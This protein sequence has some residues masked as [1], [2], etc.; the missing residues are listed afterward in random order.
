MW[1]P[2]Y[3]NKGLICEWDPTVTKSLSNQAFDPIV[4][5]LEFDK[6]MVNLQWELAIHF[7]KYFSGREVLSKIVEHAALDIKYMFG[8]DVD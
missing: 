4:M 3:R 1:H 7:V 5:D 6:D 2:K 8:C